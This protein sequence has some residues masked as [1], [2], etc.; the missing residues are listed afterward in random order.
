MT[1]KAA[2]SV[3]LAF[4]ILVAAMLW[5]RQVQSQTPPWSSAPFV[6][7]LGLVVS[8]CGSQSLSTG[9]YSQVTL[10]TGGKTC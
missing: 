8:S 1:T 2:G 5:G 10:S 9:T 4:L 7:G 3:L 6:I